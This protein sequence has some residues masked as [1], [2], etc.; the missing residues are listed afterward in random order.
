MNTSRTVQART[1]N[2]RL[3]DR[4]MSSLE[5]FVM[6]GLKESNFQERHYEEP[7]KQCLR[8]TRASKSHDPSASA[9]L[10]ACSGCRASTTFSSDDIYFFRS[11][12]FIS[13]PTRSAL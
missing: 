1:I 10:S 4:A 12:F 9:R 6:Q 13:G 11:S 7:S 3:L 8:F 2:E 5:A